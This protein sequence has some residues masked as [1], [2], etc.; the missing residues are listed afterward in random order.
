M[1]TFAT[2]E[3]I[4][5]TVVLGDCELNIASGQVQLDHVAALRANHRAAA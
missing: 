3:P 5:A 1:P 4:T 2:A